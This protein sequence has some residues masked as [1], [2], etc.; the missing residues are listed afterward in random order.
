MS[1]KFG[2]KKARRLASGTGH[3]R[4]EAD[5]CSHSTIPRAACKEK[6]S[7]LLLCCL[8]LLFLSGCERS[9]PLLGEWKGTDRDGQSVE[10][11]FHQDGTFR[12][13]TGTDSLEG[14]YTADFSLTPVELDLRVAN[15]KPLFTIIKLEGKKLTIQRTAPGQARPAGFSADSTVYTKQ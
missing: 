3:K 7:I 6:Y 14:T 10:M 2:Q 13:Y 5:A 1:A 4:L 12:A 15:S 11:V 9:S 8:A